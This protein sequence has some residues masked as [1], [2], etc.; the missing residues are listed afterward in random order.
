MELDKLAGGC[1]ISRGKMYLGR[2]FRWCKKDG[3]RG[4]IFR[5]EACRQMGAETGTAKPLTVGGF[6]FRVADFL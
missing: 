2:S 1:G 3:S 5:R 4:F 6:G